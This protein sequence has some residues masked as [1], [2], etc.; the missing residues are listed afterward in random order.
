[1]L[2]QG[3]PAKYISH[4]EE[5][6]ENFP[7]DVMAAYNIGVAQVQLNRV[8]EAIEAFDRVLWTDPRHMH[9][10]GQKALLLYNMGDAITAYALLKA[11]LEDEPTTQPYAQALPV[12][13]AAATEMK[14][15][16]D[17][18]GVSWVDHSL[19]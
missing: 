3:D 12:V 16:I 5:I 17:V 2:M 11:A 6:L 1:M 10:L 19:Y 14:K 9:A 4:L 15:R 18:R 8:T 7:S 13:E